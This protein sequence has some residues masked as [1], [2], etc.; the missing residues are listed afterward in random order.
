MSLNLNEEARR[1]SL[2]ILRN[3]MDFEEREDPLFNTFEE[4]WG[5]L[6]PQDL[7]LLP[8]PDALRAS[9][10]NK[11]ISEEADDIRKRQNLFV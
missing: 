6:L 8:I 7:V 4:V 2:E 9:I 10:E 11:L 1:E 5:Y 3:Q